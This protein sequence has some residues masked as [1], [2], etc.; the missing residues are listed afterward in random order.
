VT[1]PE[2]TITN[3]SLLDKVRITGRREGGLIEAYVPSSLVYSEDVPVDESHVKDLTSSMQAEKIKNGSTGQLSAILLGQ[4]QG[5]SQF[6][7]ID[8]FHRNRSL[9]NQ[10]VKEIFATIRP[11][12]TWEE[13]TDHRILAAATSHKSIRFAR[14]IDWVDEAWKFSPWKDSIKVSQ[15]FA[16]RFQKG[17]TGKNMGIEKDQ[18]KEIRDWVDKKCEQ[19]HISASYIYQHLLIAQT[20]DPEMV[21]DARERSSG[22]SL[23]A[24]TPLHLAAISKAIPNKFDLQKLVA[25]QVKEDMLTVKQTKTLVAE[26]AKAETPEEAGTIIAKGTWN[27]EEQINKANNADKKDD[28]KKVEHV[29]FSKEDNSQILDLDLDSFF[30]SRDGSPLTISDF[31]NFIQGSQEMEGGRMEKFLAACA[32]AGL[33][34]Q[35]E[36]LISKETFAHLYTILGKSE[37]YISKQEK[38]EELIFAEI[39]RN[40]KMNVA[41]VVVAGIRMAIADEH[42]IML[43]PNPCSL[44]RSNMSAGQLNY[45]Y[46]FLENKLNELRWSMPENPIERKRLLALRFIIGSVKEMWQILQVSNSPYTD[47]EKEDIQRIFDIKVKYKNFEE[48]SRGMLEHFS[49]RD[50]SADDLLGIEEQEETE[51]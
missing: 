5:F 42:G 1:N 20:V 18:V 50:I 2:Q 36:Q 19:W 40:L 15:A 3:E 14:L 4:V 9:Q 32:L 21:K 41:R 10:G 34:L 30:K 39:P 48:L 24:L 44:L 13:V 27:K 7:I 49:V 37:A 38:E 25:K 12:C 22:S 11:N 51:D 46:I 8:G 6:P 43:T 33:S 35:T 16:L 26:V 47:R 29:I 17:M 45:I 28:A 23:D 31:L